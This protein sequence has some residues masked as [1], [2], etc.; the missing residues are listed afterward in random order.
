[1]KPES[2]GGLGQACG[3]AATRDCAPTR[4][5]TPLLHLLTQGLAGGADL[6]MLPARHHRVY[7]IPRYS[8]KRKLRRRGDLSE[9]QG[10][11]VVPRRNTTLKGWGPE[12]A[13]DSALDIPFLSKLLPTAGRVAET[14]L[15]FA[16]L[17]LEG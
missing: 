4:D 17:S 13:L 16:P 2:T 10:V 11:K 14:A 8:E 1:M 3:A 5:R 9:S 7:P 15:S 6:W 12:D